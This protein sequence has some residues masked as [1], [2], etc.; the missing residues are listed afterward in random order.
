MCIK[1]FFLQKRNNT[2]ELEINMSSIVYYQNDGITD[3][4][5]LVYGILFLN[6]VSTVILCL[7]KVYDSVASTFAINDQLKGWK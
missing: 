3:Q 1:I 2:E 4:H 7:N 5:N 6:I